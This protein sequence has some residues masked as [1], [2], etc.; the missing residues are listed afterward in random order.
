MT[1]SFQ[2]V[3]LEKLIAKDQK[4]LF[5]LASYVLV[6]AVYANFSVKSIAIGIA[7]F[8]LYFLINGSF[9]AHAFFKKEDAF[10][11]LMFGVLLLIM[12]LGFFGWL[13]MIIHSLGDIQVALVLLITATICSLSIK[14]MN[15]KNATS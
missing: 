2:L 13:T 7:T 15:P 14:R 9:L 3:K 10:F 1:S 8:I 12:L 4:L 5:T 11:R 6:L